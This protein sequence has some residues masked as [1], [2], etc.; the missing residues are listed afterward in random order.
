MNKKNLVIV[1]A[2]AVVVLILVAGMFGGWFS[3]NNDTESITIAGST[4]VLPIAQ[5]AAEA[6]MENYSWADITVSGGGSGVGIQSVGEGTANIGMASRQIKSSESAS[7]PNLVETKIASDGIA[8]IVHPGNS[9]ASLTKNQ[10]KGIYNGTYTNWN[11]L[12]G[13]NL[14]IVMFGRDSTSG[15]REFFWESVMGKT[16]FT[17]SLLEKPSNGGIKESVKSTPGAIGYVGLGYV[18]S[19]VKALKID[20]AGTL[21]EVTAAN[22]LSGTYPISRGLYLYTTGAPTGLAKEFID[23]ILGPEGQDIVALEGFVKLP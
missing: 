17:A 4:T 20:V 8:L 3:K 13:A 5:K 18:D 11:Q 10:I 2:L 6:Y 16:N 22:V 21:V 7:Y 9:V 23:F 15:T 1:A 12:G 14:A 19:T